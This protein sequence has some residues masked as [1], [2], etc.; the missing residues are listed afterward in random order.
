MTL[1]SPDL[2]HWPGNGRNEQTKNKDHQASRIGPKKT[3][4]TKLRQ[5]ASCLMRK[6][7]CFR[8]LTCSMTRKEG[9]NEIQQERRGWIKQQT[10]TLKRTSI[11]VFQ[12]TFWGPNFRKQNH[13]EI[14][15]IAIQMS[16]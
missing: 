7:P 8:F 15:L 3:K 11:Q 14:L 6:Y 16:K 13:S 12:S 10:P 9:M 2:S 5:I 1:K 4:Q